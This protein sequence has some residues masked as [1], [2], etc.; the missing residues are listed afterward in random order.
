MR[1]LA[2]QAHRK[3][4]YRALVFDKFRLAGSSIIDPFRTC[5]LVRQDESQR[6]DIE[7]EG[8]GRSHVIHH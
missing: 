7:T 6:V 3:D 5:L 8:R 2:V 4:R 1:E